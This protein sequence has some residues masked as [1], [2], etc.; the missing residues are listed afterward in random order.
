[1]KVETL[2]VSAFTRN[3]DGGNPAG[4][5]L[6]AGELNEIQM[7]RLAGI[8]GFSE[9]AFVTAS[10][11]ADLGVRFF[12]PCAEV[13]LCGHATIATFSML[14]QTGVLQDGEYTQETKAGI[15]KIIIQDKSIFMQQAMPRYYEIIQREELLSCLGIDLNDMDDKLPV[16]IVST[17]LKDI[18]VPLKSEA[19]LKNL[20]PDMK[21]IEEISKKY[22]AVG[23]HV[24][25]AALD[26]EKFICRNFAPLYG[27]PEESATGTSN[28]ALA[29]YLH[30]YGII[31]NSDKEIIFE[32]GLYMNKPSVIKARLVLQDN[33]LAEIW[34]GGEAVL[35]EE[36]IFQ[37]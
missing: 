33:I 19:A 36:N 15:L 10:D 21:E 31:T 13:D 26:S 14:R 7:Q 20:K 34:V 6:K 30:N 18:L 32:Q 2:K 27:I 22:N 11:V 4:V 17:G 8:I 1:M 37:I 12:T 23:L 5:I 25:A 28:G 9:T 16:Q 29:C 24:F 3:I 35:L